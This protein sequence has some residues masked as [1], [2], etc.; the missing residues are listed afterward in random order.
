MEESEERDTRLPAA[1]NR[2]P[3]KSKVLKIFIRNLKC[4]LK[5]IRRSIYL[6]FPEALHYSVS[7]IYC[8]KVDLSGSCLSVFEMT[9]NS[10]Y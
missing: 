9:L 10:C 5:V 7:I 8:E 4:G 3:T 1:E 6:Y 2:W